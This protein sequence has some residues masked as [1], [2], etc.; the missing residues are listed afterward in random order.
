MTQSMFALLQNGNSKTTY[1][2]ELLKNLNSA[3]YMLSAIY[4]LAFTFRKIMG[5]ERLWV[6]PNRI[7]LS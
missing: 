1:F 4:S 5:E 7:V 6:A 3:Q 2:I